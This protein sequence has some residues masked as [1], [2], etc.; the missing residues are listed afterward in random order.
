MTAPGTHRASHVCTPNCACKGWVCWDCGT[1]QL[2]DRQ[3]RYET[4]GD[5]PLLYRP[6]LCNE[7]G[8]PLCDSCVATG[9]HVCH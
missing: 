4:E 9:G 2:V 3:T 1:S 6:E 5:T 7:C 8:A